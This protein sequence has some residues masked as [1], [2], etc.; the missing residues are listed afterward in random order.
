MNDAISVFELNAKDNSKSG[1]A[2]D[3]L[4]EGYFLAKNNTLALEKYKK[5]FELNPQNTNAK[6]MILKIENL[7]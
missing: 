5:S 3:S 1:N 4:A 6:E 2:F 7:K